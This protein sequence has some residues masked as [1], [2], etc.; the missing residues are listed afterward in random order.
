MAETVIKI[1]LPPMPRPGDFNYD[2]TSQSD[3]QRQR[4][5]EAYRRALAAWERVGV[6][7]ATHGRS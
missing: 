2:P 7:A 6:A 3:S 1:E 5:E 4:A